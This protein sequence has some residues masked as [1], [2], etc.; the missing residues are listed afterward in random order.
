MTEENNAFITF[1]KS[2]SAN[3]KIID[4]ENKK[5]EDTKRVFNGVHNHKRPL[6]IVQ[7][8]TTSDVVKSI[9]YARE[10]NIEIVA[11]GGGHSFAGYSI[12]E[13]GIVVDFSKMRAIIVDRKTNT[14][15]IQPGLLGRDLDQELNQYNLY[16]VT[17][18]VSNTGV[19]GLMLHGGFGIL[20]NSTGFALKSVLE[21]EV[22]T[23]DGEVLICNENENKELFWAMKG[24]PS[25]YGMV[26]R[27]KI[28]CHEF[29][30]KNGTIY[31]ALRVY[32]SN[33]IFKCCQ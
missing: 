10:N 21:L 11:R 23:A 28:Q 8:S 22:V 4:R 26:T 3:C 17:G 27:T 1:K 30:T 7:P 16:C 12:V 5:Y 25:N 31:S 24:S 15:I 9:K 32:P 29:K 20:T 18:T 19:T 14:A 33:G 13:N 6:F 2:L